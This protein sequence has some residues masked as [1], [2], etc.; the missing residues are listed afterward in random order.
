M[1]G[2]AHRNT[3]RPKRPE[4]QQGEQ[5][6]NTCIA[7]TDNELEVIVGG[8]PVALI[9]IAAVAYMGLLTKIEN[10]PDQYTWTMDW[11]Y[12]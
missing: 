2:P 3:F 4:I 8:N 10:N 6:M 7:L 12:G 1:I 5:K 9:G 11:Y